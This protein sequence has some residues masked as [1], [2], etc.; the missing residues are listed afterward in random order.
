MENWE[1]LVFN[2]VEVKSY[3]MES[4]KMNFG[5]EVKALVGC[6]EETATNSKRISLKVSG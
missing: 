6:S 2:N 5:I 4:C 1:R 3:H